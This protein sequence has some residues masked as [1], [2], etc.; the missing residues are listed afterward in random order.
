MI[1]KI[2]LVTLMSF[3]PWSFLCI[4]E[5]PTKVII[6]SD[7]P[8]LSSN[9]EV[10]SSNTYVLYLH[11]SISKVLYKRDSVGDDVAPIKGNYVG[12]STYAAI[13]RVNT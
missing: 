11:H 12:N 10:L 6:A 3:L 9:S 13:L 7:A 8:P 4:S 2:F 1:S 5:A